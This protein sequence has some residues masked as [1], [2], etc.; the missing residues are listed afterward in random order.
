MLSPP[1][2]HKDVAPGELTAEDAEGGLLHPQPVFQP[3]WRG[4][5]LWLH[6]LLGS[7][8]RGDSAGQPSPVAMGPRLVGKGGRTS[9][10]AASREQGSPKHEVGASHRPRE[11]AVAPHF[12]GLVA[13]GQRQIWGMDPMLEQD[14]RCAEDSRAAGGHRLLPLHPSLAEETMALGTELQTPLGLPTSK[15]WGR[16]KWVLWGRGWCHALAGGHG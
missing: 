16:E 9:S 6:G 5:E 2:Q 11:N 14:C 3:C 4:C 1:H 10:Q 7:M 8:A 12:P 13:K 15:R